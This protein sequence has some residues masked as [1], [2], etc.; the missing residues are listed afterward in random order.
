MQEVSR[1]FDFHATSE[2]RYVPHEPALVAAR[3]AA[4]AAEPARPSV[5]PRGVVRH[6]RATALWRNG[7][8]RRA[9]QL[10]YPAPPVFIFLIADG[11]GDD[12][13]A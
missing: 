5:A 3:P 2:T 13:N 9:L 4:A 10:V 6:R 12:V 1:D 8:E 11:R 7:R